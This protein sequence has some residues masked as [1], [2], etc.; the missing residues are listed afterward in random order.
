M[1]TAT[2]SGPLQ[3]GTQRDPQN[4]N[5]G[6]VVLTQTAQ[7]VRDATLVQNATIRLPA[8]AEILD[9][10]A[11]PTVAYD[12]LT[13]ATLSI[14]YTSGGTQYASGIDVKTA[15]VKRMTLT[16]AIAALY[17]NILTNTTMVATVT[18]VGQ[19]TVGT[20]TI[21]VVYRQR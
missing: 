11:M 4:S 18:S 3:V 8:N 5:L 6:Q 12:S 7:V 1:G 9:I 13:S 19:P 21:V 2:F 15:G 10:Y 16:A 14:G 17:R 20:V